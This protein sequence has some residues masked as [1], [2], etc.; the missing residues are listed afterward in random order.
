MSPGKKV[1]L[2]ILD[3]WGEA[4]PGDGNAIALANT[5][6][7]DRIRS[8]S[9]YAPLRTSGSNVGLPDGQMGNSEVGHLNIGAGRIVLQELALINRAF[10]SGELERNETLLG[11]FRY[12]TENDKPLH[13]AG[14]VSDGGV[15]S[16][17]NHLIG[18]CR[19]ARAHGVRRLY[20]HAFTDGR[21]T[22]PHSALP[23]LQSVDDAVHGTGARFVSLVGRYYAMD[24]DHR[25][26][27]IRR[28]YDLLVHGKGQRF[29]GVAEALEASYANGVTDEFVEPAGLVSGGDEPVTVRPGDAFLCFNFR[30]DRCRQLT[31][32]LTQQDIPGQDMKTLPLRYVTMTR[33]DVAF[34]GVDVVFDK[35]HLT[36]TLGEVLSVAGKRQLRISETEK[37][38]H[39]TFF[40]SGGR[41]APFPGEDRILIPS[42]KVATYDLK[43]SMSAVEVKDAL[44]DALGGGVYDFVCVNFANADMVG[45]TGV[46]EAA[47]EACETVDR[48]AQEIVQAGLASGYVF[49]ITAD[50]GNAETMRNPD[51]T[52]NTAHTLHTVPC[53][54][55]DDGEASVHLRPGILADLAPTVLSLMHIAQPEEMTGKTLLKS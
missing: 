33:Y 36:H 30:T 17:G 26:E 15:H 27:R 3:G 38:P 42:P 4:P 25:W 16:H 28:A 52:P 50:H 46:L 37:Y 29:A 8:A 34:R 51:G 35:S 41:E 13:L 1:V 49:L 7:M 39:V 32:A 54:Y 31:M 40:F 11:L 22:D 48:C 23:Y 21:D 18:L 43:P 45:H 24:R 53:F 6:F 19:L 5:P 44:V 9:P 55:V 2:M 14:L 12:C 47:V 10:D 20:I